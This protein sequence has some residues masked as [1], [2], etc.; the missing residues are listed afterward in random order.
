MRP[1]TFGVPEK[2][3]PSSKSA[4][5]FPV[6]ADL[7][8]VALLGWSAGFGSSCEAPSDAC[9]TCVRALPCAW[10]QLSFAAMSSGF[11]VWTPPGDLSEMQELSVSEAEEFEQITVRHRK[12]G[13]KGDQ[14]P[15]GIWAA[16]PLSG[17]SL[18][19]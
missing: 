15:S 1:A 19:L 18:L 12:A 6:R 11:A 3:T 4:F 13:G 9:G 2:D 17:F 7:E 16:N 8:R 14:K 5:Y 10:V